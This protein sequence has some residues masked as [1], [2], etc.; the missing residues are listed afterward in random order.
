MD[1]Y[2]NLTALVGR[3]LLA[4]LFVPSGFGKLTHLAGTAALMEHKGGIPHAIVYPALAVT[5]LIEFGGSLLVV[6]GYKARWAA[7]LI[8]LWMI[9]V[10]MLFHFLPW[11]EAAAHGNATV[12]MAQWG[13]FMKNVS[14]MADC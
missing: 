14:V 1:R 2:R 4:L 12:A 8:F 11:R 5:I 6:L 3:V 9:P 13:N 10:T 7:L